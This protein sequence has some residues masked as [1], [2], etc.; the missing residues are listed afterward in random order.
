MSYL[1][2]YD[3]ARKK[4]EK[5]K[6]SVMSLK[7]LSSVEAAH[8]STDWNMNQNERI[9]NGM[10]LRREKLIR[11]LMIKAIILTI[12]ILIGSIFFHKFEPPKN[13]K[14]IESLH[15]VFVTMST[16]GYGNEFPQSDIGKAVASMYVFVGL[17]VVGVFATF[18]T[19]YIRQQ[20]HDKQ[21]ITILNNTL[22]NEMDL[23]MFD[24]DGRGNVSKFEFLCTMLVITNETSFDVIERILA[25]F[26]EL[27]RDNNNQIS[28]DDL[29]SEWTK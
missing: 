7:R 16:V 1:F 4:R 28:T 2:L 5:I 3:H 27:D 14:Y 25:K 20:H 6:N 12:I 18:I 8:S 17:A 29:R 13:E 24:L 22:L 10:R 19:D 15:F 9:V 23:N 26:Q 21:L 11:L